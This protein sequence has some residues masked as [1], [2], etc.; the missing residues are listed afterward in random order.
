M[1]NTLTINSIVGQCALYVAHMANTTYVQ[2]VLIEK[3]LCMYLSGLLWVCT[4]ILGTMC[5]CF[6]CMLGIVLKRQQNRP[7][8]HTVPCLDCYTVV[9]SILCKRLKLVLRND[10]FNLKVLLEIPDSHTHI[11]NI[12]PL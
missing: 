2:R 3:V 10:I 1:H 12:N 11:N 5:V 6:L 8:Q 4:I 7:K 9:T